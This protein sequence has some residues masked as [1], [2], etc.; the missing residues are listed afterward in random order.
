[1][2]KHH[3]TTNR[4]RAFYQP[5]SGG[6]VLKRRRITI[7]LFCVSCQPPSGGCVLKQP[8]QHELRHA[9]A[10]AAFRRLCVET[11]LPK[12][13][14]ECLTQPPSGGCVLKLDR[15]SMGEHSGF[16]PPSGG[17]VLKRPA[18]RAIKSVFIQPPSGG[19][20]LKLRIAKK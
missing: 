18:M 5:P 1:M 15:M 13:M 16:Q 6:C 9:L 20:V 10:P 12:L 4:I 8:H 14:K 3:K 7:C 17:C 11:N 2:L 19:C